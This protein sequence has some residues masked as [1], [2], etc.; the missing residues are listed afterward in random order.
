MPIDRYYTQSKVKPQLLFLSNLIES[1]GVF[2]LLEALKILIDKGVEFECSFVGGEGD[3]DIP[4]FEDKVKK[5]KLL[6]KVKYLGKKY[7][8]DKNLIFRNTDIFCFP[9]A[10]PNECFPLVLLEAMQFSLP[11]VTTN[12]G[13]ISEIV[14]DNF[15][16]FIVGKNNSIELAEKIE[17]LINDSMKRELMGERSLELYKEKFKLDIFESRIVDIFNDILSP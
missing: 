12:E 5:L 17:I 8:E 13:G 4:S 2:V 9:T 6:N 3:I 7:N 15:N 16:G 14:K 1:K 11:I 10:Y